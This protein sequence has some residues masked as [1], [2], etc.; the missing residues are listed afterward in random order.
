[1]A[2]FRLMFTSGEPV[3]H[4]DEEDPAHALLTQYSQSLAAHPERAESLAL[5]AWAIVHGIAMLMLDGRIPAD[6]ALLDRLLAT[7]SLFPTYSA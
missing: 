3:D 2:L 5:Q 6:D 4:S 1:P 7:D